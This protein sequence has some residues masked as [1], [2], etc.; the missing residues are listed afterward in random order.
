MTSKVVLVALLA[1]VS[2][3][4][5]GSNS[6]T[7]GAA[8]AHA[9]R[10]ELTELSLFM[11]TQVNPPFS[12]LSFLLFH[13]GDPSELDPSMLPAAA[14]ELAAA[15]TKLSEWPT[16]YGDSE[17]AQQ[18]FFEYAASLRNNAANLAQA[19]TADDHDAARKNF[20]ELRGNCDSCHHFFRFGETSSGAIE[21]TLVPPAE[22]P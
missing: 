11:K 9:K 5:F 19:V 17:Q 2:C 18:V 15:T 22:A 3:S 14:Q 20:E 8:P 12:K 10:S 7:G 4:R 16:P 6:G 13:Q 21:P 1:V